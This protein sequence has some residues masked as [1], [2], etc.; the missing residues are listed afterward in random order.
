M[1]DSL[2]TPSAG[3]DSDLELSSTLKLIRDG[4]YS[5]VPDAS[6]GI[7]SHIKDLSNDV[8]N[9]QRNN[10][11]GLVQV[12]VECGEAMFSLAEMTRDIREVNNRA[13]AIA[14]AAEEMVASVQDIATT[15]DAAAGDANQVEET[16]AKGMAAAEQ[17]VE[18]MHNITRA[19]EEA[20]AKVDTLAEASARIGDIVGSIEAIAKQTNLLALNATIEAARAGEAG[21]G[22]AVVASE[23]KTLANQTA[24]A[25]DDI[26]TRIN[27]LRE[28]MARIVV[29]MEEGAR[30]VQEGE[31]VIVAT[32][33]EMRTIAQRI[34]AVTTRMQDIAAIL[35]QQSEASHEVSQGVNVIADMADRNNSEVSQVVDAMDKAA[36]IISD[37][38][39]DLDSLDITHKV[40]DIAKS[41]HVAFK[42]RIMD[43]A[44]GRTF[45]TAD[46]IPDHRGCRLGKWYYDVKES[47]VRNDPAFRELEDPHIRVHGHGKKALAALG[48]GDMDTAYAEIGKLAMASTEVLDLLDRL[49]NNLSG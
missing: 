46:E 38:L 15:S 21:K 11:R 33:D 48:N 6:D 32:G 4:K 44:I 23:V 26:R 28:E 42:K 2:T 20:A 29:S 5:E 17:A 40:V 31:E 45:V 12:S 41:D 14:T 24:A 30:A 36:A 13:Q 1:N 18:T 19:V 3:D 35:S 25:T 43:A 10:L 49:S 7:G 9:Q 47:A 8:E 27:G 37:R 39:S 16:A 34:G 22:F